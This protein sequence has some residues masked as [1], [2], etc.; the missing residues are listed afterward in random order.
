MVGFN[1]RFAPAVQLAK[2]LIAEGRIGKIFHF[3]GFFLQDWIVDPQFPLVWRLQ[4]EI[5]GSGSHGDLGA[6]VI[7]MARFLVG[8]FNEVIG[9][10]ETFIKER[11]LPTG[12]TGLSAK[13]DKDAPKGEVT[14]DDATLFLA[15]FANGALGS[16]EATRF[17]P[18]IAARTRSRSTA[19]KAASSSILS[20]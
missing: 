20:A 17:A 11:P 14:V 6:H 19:A 2:K 18:D 1:Y 13:G 7:D 9:M 3:R 5:A 15:R 16:I 12:M 8:E 4:K 10:S